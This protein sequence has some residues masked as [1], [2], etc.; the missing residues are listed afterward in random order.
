MDYLMK[1]VTTALE[2]TYEAGESD[3][4]LETLEK[5]A[6]LLILR[7]D[8]LRIIDGEGPRIEAP[9]SEVAQPE[10]GRESEAQP[11]ATRPSRMPNAVRCSFSGIIPID[12]EQFQASGIALVECPACGATRTLQPQRGVLRFSSHDQRKTVPTAQRW[13]RLESDWAVVGG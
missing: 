7:R 12:L 13:A 3:V 2:W 11:E 4:Q 1:L 8:T 9:L 5:A 10:N 6:S